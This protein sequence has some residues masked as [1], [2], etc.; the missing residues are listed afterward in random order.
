MGPLDPHQRVEVVALAPDEPA[1]QLVGVELV[2]IAE[3]RARYET[4]ASCAGVI[5][6]G[7]NGSRVVVDMRAPGDLATVPHH[8]SLHTVR[9]L[10]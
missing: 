7:W 5:A 2:G 8:G 10:A 3:Y 1:T 9:Q 4:A 6:S